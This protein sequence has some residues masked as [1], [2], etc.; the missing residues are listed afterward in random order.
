MCAAF[1]VRGPRW[2]TGRI[3]V[4]GSMANQSQ[5]TCVEQRSLVRSSSNLRCGSRRLRDASAG[6]R[7]V[8][9]PQHESE[10]RVMVA[11]R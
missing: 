2:S 5:S 3:F 9:T 4:R 1:W 6:A 11:W 7:S 8:R 10:R